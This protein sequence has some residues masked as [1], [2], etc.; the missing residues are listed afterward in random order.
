MGSRILSFAMLLGAWSLACCGVKQHNLIVGE[1]EAA[2]KPKR[3]APANTAVKYVHASGDWYQLRVSLETTHPELRPSGTTYKMDLEAE[4]TVHKFNRKTEAYELVSRPGVAD[5]DHDLRFF[6][7]G[8]D[9]KTIY[10]TSTHGGASGGDA[11][12]PE[13]NLTLAE[14]RF[15]P[16]LRPEIPHAEDELE[17]EIIAVGIVNP[18]AR[19]KR[20][21]PD[22]KPVTIEISEKW[23]AEALGNERATFRR[24]E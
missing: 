17:F 16:T 19:E 7:G 23:L 12:W 11:G 18:S 10:L 5:A 4:V 6:F 1:P 3:P 24:L 14:I 8:K 2:P 13:K 15:S 21:D 22:A 9:D 20:E